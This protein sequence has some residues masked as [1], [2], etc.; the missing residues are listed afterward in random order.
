[1]G[2]VSG[3]LDEAGTVVVSTFET[4]LSMLNPFDKPA[5][6]RT[7]RRMYWSPMV[8]HR[9]AGLEKAAVEP[10][11]AGTVLVVVSDAMHVEF[12]PKGSSSAA[13]SLPSP[14]DVKMV[15]RE[16]DLQKN[17]FTTDDKNRVALYCYDDAR[18]YWIRE[19]A[20]RRADTLFVNTTQTGTWALGIEV[21]R[22]DDAFAPDILETGPHGMAATRTPEI[23]A[24]IR[25]GEYG[26]GVDLSRTRIV[27]DA[28]T[29]VTTHDPVNDRFSGTPSAKLPDGDHTVTVI[30]V[31]LAGNTRTTTFTFTVNGMDVNEEPRRFSVSAPYPNPFNPVTLIRFTLPDDGPVE[32]AVY[33]VRG[34]KVAVLASGYRRAGTYDV[35]WDGR[36]SDG[37]TAASGVYLYRLRAG[38]HEA[39]GKL[40][41]VK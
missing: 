24:R 35:K 18:R 31:D 21:A 28:D 25:D 27:V 7:V 8:L 16:S 15:I 19:N 1:V 30:A 38:I 32:F 4:G 5:G 17:Q 9:V 12:I 11:G 22:T 14:V 26:A 20:S 3:T 41:L 2:E 13:D 34:A 40:M 10:A 23:Y 6:S 39:Q 33:D 36:S 37:T 29:L